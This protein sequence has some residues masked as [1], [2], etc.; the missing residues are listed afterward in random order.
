MPVAGNCNFLD[1]KRGTGVESCGSFRQPRTS[2]MGR[3]R[4]P[5]AS[6]SSHQ[7]RGPQ[8]C[9]SARHQERGRGADS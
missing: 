5:D 8:R 3:A 9:Q 1:E 7:A 2:A 6:G 4:P